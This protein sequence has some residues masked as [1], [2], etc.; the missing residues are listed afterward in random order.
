MDLQNLINNLTAHKSLNHLIGKAEEAVESM[1]PQHEGSFGMYSNL[2]ELT[3]NPKYLEK[4]KKKIF[5]LGICENPFYHYL[6]LY[7]IT[8]EKDWLE[9]V[10]RFNNKMWENRKWG[11]DAEVEGLMKIYETSKDNEEIETARELS[12]NYN[13]EDPIKRKSVIEAFL[14]I[15][16]TT[17]DKNDL[18][19]ARNR[20][21]ALRDF[22]TDPIQTKTIAD[23]STEIYERSGAYL[24]YRISF[25]LISDSKKDTKNN[26]DYCFWRLGRAAMLHN[27]NEKKVRGLLKLVKETEWRFNFFKKIIS[28][29]YAKEKDFEEIITQIIPKIYVTREDLKEI[30]KLAKEKSKK[31]FGELKYRD[32]LSDST[33]G[34]TSDCISYLDNLEN[35]SN[36]EFNNFLNSSFD[37]FINAFKFSN[38]LLANENIKTRFVRVL[39][40]HKNFAAADEIAE[41]VI[42]PFYRFDAFYSIAK[43]MFKEKK[44]LVN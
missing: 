27:E 19:E 16:D 35:L 41:K 42:H 29:K 14:H 25:S 26:A 8:K 2:Y 10:R 30:E 15:Y 40:K 20:L 18:K 7:K 32:V 37:S 38:D 21:K 33:K 17:K 22:K 24:D 4:M 3:K 28:S 1:N 31:T 44:E 23:I 12:R 39:A 34:A 36:D 11:I 6:E 5:N 13:S 43:E 9:R